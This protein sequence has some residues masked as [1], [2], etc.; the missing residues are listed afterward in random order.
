M[1]TFFS[2]EKKLEFREK[3]INEKIKFRKFSEIKFRF[4]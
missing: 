3:K 1:N 2:D 4:R